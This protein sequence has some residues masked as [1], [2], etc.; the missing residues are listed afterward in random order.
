MT[1]TRPIGVFD[2]GLGGLSV[3]RHIRQLLPAERLYYVADSAYAPYGDKPESDIQQRSTVITRYLI[4][5]DIKALVVACNTATA[6]AIETL[7]ADFD[8]PIIGM[9]PA[10]KPA[11]LLTQ[12]GVVGILAT[13]GTLA[14]EKYARL[15][16][17]FAENVKI[18]SQPCPGLVEQVEKAELESGQTRELVTRYVSALLEQGADTLVLGCTHYPFLKSLVEDVAGV[19]VRVL[20]TGEAV[21]R[22]LQRRLDQAGILTADDEHSDVCFFSNTALSLNVVDQ[23]WNGSLIKQQLD[24]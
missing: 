4:S 20:D 12:S 18:I 5:H 15:Y 14:S 9:E 13:P 19:S 1:D 24:I 16:Q 3:L 23:L 11:A 6:A 21:A 7:R 2:S 17:Q 10:V 8:L 22:E